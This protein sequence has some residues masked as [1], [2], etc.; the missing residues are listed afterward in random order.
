[1][2]ERWILNASPLI[3][4]SRIGQ[5]RLLQVQADQVVVPFAVAQEI[6]AG[7]ANDRARLALEA[8]RFTIID[9]LPPP[10]EI[11]AW[12]LGAGE[13]AVLTSALA[14]PGWIAILDD[15][16]ARKCARSFSLKVKGT[17]AVVLQAKQRGLIS[18]AV[19]VLR[20]LRESGFRLDDRVIGEALAR[21]TGENWIP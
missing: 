2:G 10:A 7:P 20:S 9:T 17:L 5:E 4:L 15:Q 6:Q 14:E 19:D 12:D 21:T 11:L 8:G 18:S 16:A 13:T 3:V 1:M